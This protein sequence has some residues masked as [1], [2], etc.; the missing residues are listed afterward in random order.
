MAH[1]GVTLACRNYD[2]TQAILRG[3]IQI[4][5]VGLRVVE[6]NDVTSLFG[7]LFHGEY[8]AAEMSLGELVYYVSR[9]KNDFVGIPVFPS[10]FFRHGFILCRSSA[11]IAS[12]EELRGKKIGFL[13]WV[14]TAAIWI[15][16]IL[17]EEHGVSPTANDWYAISM[18]HW[19]G[20]ESGE[21]SWPRT[22]YN[23]QALAEGPADPYERACQALL[24]GRIDI[25]GSTENE[26]FRR[27]TA[28]A[29]RGLFPD[30]KAA[31]EAYYRKTGIFPIMHVLAVRKAALERNPDLP[32]QLFRL[33]SESKKMARAW[34]RA[35]PSQ[36]IVWKGHYLE[37]EEKFFGGDPWVYG[38][39]ANRHVITKFLAYCHDQGICEK[40]M[41]PK[42]LFHPGT[43]ALEE[44]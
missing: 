23:V 24:S 42:D 34:L 25:L 6:N 22:R 1:D 9:G 2:G 39:R 4:P 14:Q 10:R 17:V 32:E 33:F 21:D 37:A 11:P 15:R 5:G 3:Q 29:V 8:D 19:E 41:E 36:G 16:G 18:H 44:K 31:E 20:G 35:I 26:A 7:G 13:R 30:P 38:L 27:K 12:P 28:G 43:W 40:P